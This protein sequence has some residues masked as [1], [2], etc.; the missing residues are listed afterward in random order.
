M[1]TTKRTYPEIAAEYAPYNTFQ[2]FDE[3][4]TAYM[5]RR[6]DNPYVDPRDGVKAQAWGLEA[7]MRYTRQHG[8]YA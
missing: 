2:A 4:T 6:Y 8:R 7:A 5:E 1:P 3:G